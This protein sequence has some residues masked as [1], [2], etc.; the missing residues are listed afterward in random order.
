MMK[1]KLFT[2]LVALA[3]L[4][5]PSGTVLASGNDPGA[6]SSQTKDTDT[7]KAKM[8]L[9]TLRTAYSQGNQELF[10]RN[11]DEIPALDYHLLKTNVSQSSIDHSQI[12]LVI[13]TDHILSEKGKVAIKTHWQKRFVNNSTGTLEKSEG[14]AEFL[15]KITKNAAYLL[16]IRGDNP[17]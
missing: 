16:D 1:G 3:F 13:F 2:G 15:F 12:E 10:F 5:T 11:V 14:Q 17:F 4:M 9:E 6:S 8:A 7:D